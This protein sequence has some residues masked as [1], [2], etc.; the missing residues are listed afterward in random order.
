MPYVLNVDSIDVALL[1]SLGLCLS[2]SGVLEKGVE[3]RPG[4]R[5]CGGDTF[6][7]IVDAKTGDVNSTG[8]GILVRLGLLAYDIIECCE[9]SGI[10]VGGP[11]MRALFA[12]LVRLVK[13]LEAG[14]R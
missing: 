12:L 7:I 9:D 2:P 10:A 14:S 5:R 6:F 8:A 13:L 11:C 3:R 4:E 1:P